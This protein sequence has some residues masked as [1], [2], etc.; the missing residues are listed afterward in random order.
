MLSA[1]ARNLSISQ[2]LCI[3]APPINRD[4]DASA[5]TDW[6]LVGALGNGIDRLGEPSADILSW[7]SMQHDASTIRA[8]TDR[9]WHVETYPLIWV[10]SDNS[11][12]LPDPDRGPRRV[13]ETVFCRHRGS[14]EV[15]R[16]VSNAYSAPSC[17]LFHMSAKPEGM[18][19]RFFRMVVDLTD[20]HSSSACSL[21]KKRQLRFMPRLVAA[22]IGMKPSRWSIRRYEPSKQ[23]VTTRVS[24]PGR[25]YVVRWNAKSNL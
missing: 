18:F 6:T 9:G 25:K 4:Y 15:V 11:G 2:A 7:F 16:A 17:K 23:G 19:H 3:A 1:G 5:E 14:R 12:I 22:G 10:R 21:Q 24:G 8:L 13:Y 20:F